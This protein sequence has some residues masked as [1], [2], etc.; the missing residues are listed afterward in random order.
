MFAGREDGGTPNRAFALNIALRSPTE[1]SARVTEYNVCNT[2]NDALS[3]VT[4]ILQKVESDEA[5]LQYN[6]KC[7]SEEARKLSGSYYTPVD[8]ASFFW[9][10]FFK[11]KSIDCSKDALELIRNH[12]LVEPSA[13]SG[14]LILAL[15]RELLYLGVSVNALRDLDLRIIDINNSALNYIRQKI[16]LMNEDIGACVVQPKYECADFREWSGV[17]LARPA[18][19]FGNPPFVLNPRGSTWKNL[20]ADFLS[21]CIAKEQQCAAFQFI[22]PLSIS[23]SRDYSLL[24]EMLRNDKF[25]IMASHFDNIPDTLF[26]SG[27]PR[28]T[29]TNKANSQ[30]CTILSGCRSHQFSIHSTCLHRW[31]KIE[32]PNFLSRTPSFFDVSEYEFDDQFLR[33]VSGKMSSYLQDNLYSYRLEALTQSSGKYQLHVGSVARNYISFRSCGGSSINSFFFSSR[34][35]L[36]QFLGMLASDVYLDYWRSVGDGFHV[37]RGNIINFPVSSDLDQAVKS[38]LSDIDLIWRR[39]RRYVKTKRNSGHLVLSYDLSRAMPSLH[40]ILQHS[41]RK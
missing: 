16:S 3:L 34:E 27:K 7:K 11:S 15:I 2:H 29:N 35:K 36:L 39:R 12:T 20:Y 25:R 24:R 23:F 41:S 21:K 26:K 31:S 5:N 30:R 6:T 4:S 17:T 40:S 38:I 37:T 18:I 9:R 13:G 33:P 32:R 19:Y 14:V 28:H 22:L 8:V 10:Q 1:L